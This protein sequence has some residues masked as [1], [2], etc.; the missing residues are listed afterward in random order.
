MKAG[1]QPPAAAACRPFGHQPT[2]KT[3][4]PADTPSPPAGG[5][6]SM[7][8]FPQNFFYFFIFSKFVLLYSRR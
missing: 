6:P 4:P 8:A 3:P 7:V 1:H 2:P 5:T